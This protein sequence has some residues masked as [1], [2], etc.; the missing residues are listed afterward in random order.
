MEFTGAARLLAL[1]HTNSKWSHTFISNTE[2]V[3]LDAD[4]HCEDPH[5]ANYT[6][7]AIEKLRYNPGHHQYC[8]P[9]KCKLSKMMTWPAKERS[10]ANKALSLEI[11]RSSDF[12]QLIHWHLVLF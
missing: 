9:I 5:R 7:T 4:M 10:Y 1:N 6:F 8:V 12:L 3:G 11:G 2:S